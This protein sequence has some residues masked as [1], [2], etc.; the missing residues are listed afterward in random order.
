MGASQALRGEHRTPCSFWQNCQ[1]FRQFCTKM[2]S[3]PPRR[4]WGAAAHT[5][6]GVMDWMSLSP[7]N[8]CVKLSPSVRL[9]GGGTFGRWLHFR[10][11]H[12]GGVPM[13]GSVPLKE[14]EEMPGVPLSPP[15]EGTAGRQEESPR[16]EPNWP[17]LRSQ[18]SSPQ[19]CEQ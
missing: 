7:Q 17:A 2:K 4:P 16:Q 6:K 19:N 15:C 14:E 9:S 12:K 18:T 8:A 10:C 1:G 11:G 5:L 13:M 3:P